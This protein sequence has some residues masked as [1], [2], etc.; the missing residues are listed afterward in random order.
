MP[1]AMNLALDIRTV[2]YALAIAYAGHNYGLAAFAHVLQAHV[3]VGAQLSLYRVRAVVKEFAKQE[4]AQGCKAAPIERELLELLD[5]M[6]VHLD[7][8]GA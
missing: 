8:G 7:G 4:A 2:R 3:D 1:A 5:S 6:G